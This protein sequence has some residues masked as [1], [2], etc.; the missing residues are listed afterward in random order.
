MHLQLCEIL[1]GFLWCFRA[2]YLN[3]RVFS[4]YSFDKFML[5]RT[6]VFNHLSLVGV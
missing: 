3:V 4:K 5:N 1:N 6:Q 2:S